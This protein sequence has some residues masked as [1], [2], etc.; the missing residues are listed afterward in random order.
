MNT[1]CKFCFLLSIFSP[2]SSIRLGHL[3]CTLTLE[4]IIIYIVHH[5]PHTTLPT[6]RISHQPSHITHHTPHTTVLY[7]TTQH[8]TTTEFCSGPGRL[9]PSSFGFLYK[10]FAKLLSPELADADLKIQAIKY[11]EAVIVR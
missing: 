10:F 6:P 2:V 4:L 7:N 3:L 5:T 1:L 9:F 8:N 11:H